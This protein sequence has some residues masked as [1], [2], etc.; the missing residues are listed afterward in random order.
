MAN[1]IPG[2]LFPE[3]R[4]LAKVGS[5]LVHIEEGFGEDGHSFDLIAIKTL[6]NDPDVR[7]WIEGMRKLALV[8]VK[9]K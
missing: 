8:P 3:V 2:P 1:G 6:L 5:I 7:H 9:R 4:V